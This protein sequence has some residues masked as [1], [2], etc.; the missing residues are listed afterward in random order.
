MKVFSQ[1]SVD[2]DQVNPHPLHS[3]PVDTISLNSLSWHSSEAVLAATTVSGLLI[4][5]R[6]NER[7]DGEKP[8]SRPEITLTN[9]R[10]HEEYD[11]DMPDTTAAFEDSFLSRRGEEMHIDEES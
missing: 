11:D 2:I 8:S 9:S 1:V 4:L 7:S 3:L 10:H 5:T 6:I